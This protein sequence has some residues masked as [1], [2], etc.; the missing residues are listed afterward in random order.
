MVVR[1]ARGLLLRFV[2]RRVLAVVVGLALAAPALW[3]ELGAHTE[4][5]WLQGLSMIVAATGAAILWTGL[6]GVK[7]DWIDKS[8]VSPHKSHDD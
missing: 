7:P 3:S 8:E 5:P 6:A 1:R 4:S 2:R